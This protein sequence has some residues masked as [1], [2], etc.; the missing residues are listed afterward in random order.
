MTERAKIRDSLDVFTA[1]R[2]VQALAAAIGFAPITCTELAIVVSELATNIL[3][4]GVR[5]EI[6]VRRTQPP[7]APGIEIIAE[8]EGPP[9]TNLEMAVRD[10]CGDR[11]P[12]GPDELFGRGGIG[13]G[14]GAVIRLSDG[15]E[16]HL[17]PDRKHFRV[18]RYLH[19]ATR[20]PRLPTE[21]T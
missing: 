3:K 7:A 16:Y 21:R 15:F 14:L 8:D 19:L 11:G 13:G 17:G 2:K 6:A 12:I 9:L 1:R 10:G 4:Y 5:G 18:V 20:G